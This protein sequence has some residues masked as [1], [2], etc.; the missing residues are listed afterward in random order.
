[1]NEKQLSETMFVCTSNMHDYIT[2]LYDE[3]LHPLCGV[4]VK[5]YDG[6]LIAKLRQ[7]MS[8]IESEKEQIIEAIKEYKNI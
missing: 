3:T 1:M 6:K 7:F 5:D 8:A 4:P 2:E